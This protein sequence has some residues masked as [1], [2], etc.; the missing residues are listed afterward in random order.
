MR[1]SPRRPCPRPRIVGFICPPERGAPMAKSPK[2]PRVKP[3]EPL[4]AAEPLPVKGKPIIPMED[5]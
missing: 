1:T 5:D 4:Y 2:I 3:G